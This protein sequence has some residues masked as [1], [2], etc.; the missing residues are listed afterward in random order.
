MLQESISLGML[1]GR[2]MLHGMTN[3]SLKVDCFR[4][5]IAEYTGLL[6]GGHTILRGITNYSLRVDT[7]I[8]RYTGLLLVGRTTLPGMANI[9]QG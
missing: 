9:S 7:S 8:T 1:G 4:N 2:T 6:L 5:R 3:N